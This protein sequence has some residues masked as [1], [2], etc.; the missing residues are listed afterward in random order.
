MAEISRNPWV[1][2]DYA[3]KIEGHINEIERALMAER[4]FLGDEV[5]DLDSNCKKAVE[6][7]D[8]VRQKL[9]KQLCDYQVLVDSLNKNADALIDVFEN[10]QI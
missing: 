6:N 9:H 3:K 7:F 10:N 4:K 2:K 8:Q 1:M 5:I